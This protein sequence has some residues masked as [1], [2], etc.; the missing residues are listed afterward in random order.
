M[1]DITASHTLHSESRGG[2]ARPPLL[3]DP[4]VLPGATNESVTDHIC[5]IALRDRPYLWW[6][7]AIIPAVLLAGVLVIAI[8]WL[9]YAGV[10][11][12]TLKIFAEWS[13]VT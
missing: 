7:I 10:G 2:D 9:F 4:V 6:W 13:Q 1:T 8:S 3:S 5:A 12:F 11:I